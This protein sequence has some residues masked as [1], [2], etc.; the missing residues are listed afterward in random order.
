M[1]CFF[2]TASLQRLKNECQTSRS[3]RHKHLESLQNFLC[4]M[5]YKN[6]MKDPYENRMYCDVQDVLPFTTV[7]IC[8]VMAGK[9]VSLDQ[10]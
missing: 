1:R 9:H 4:P 2:Q 8:G 10:L 6:V 7:F 5:A 3:I